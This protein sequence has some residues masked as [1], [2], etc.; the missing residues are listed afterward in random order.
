[1]A[2]IE[3]L[4]FLINKQNGDITRLTNKA[5]ESLLRGH[6]YIAQAYWDAAKLAHT[7]SITKPYE[8]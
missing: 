3:V 1:M 4:E 6:V 2:T 7:R 5:T 8:G